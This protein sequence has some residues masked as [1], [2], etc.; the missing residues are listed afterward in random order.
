MF[1]KQPRLLANMHGKIA[2][3]VILVL[4]LAAIGVSVWSQMMPTAALQFDSSRLRIPSAALLT[5][6]MLP[7]SIHNPGWNTAHIV[8]C[9][10]NG[11]G[12]GGCVYGIEPETFDLAPGETKKI[13]VHYKSPPISGPFEKEFCIFSATNTLNKH[14][15]KVTGVAVAEKKDVGN[16]DSIDTQEKHAEQP[17]V[18]HRDS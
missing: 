18:S 2:G 4:G 10:G 11:C 17:D 15:L 6:K 14:K 7:I 5:E 9:Q 12:P 13:L 8:G 1:M 3:F 16:Q